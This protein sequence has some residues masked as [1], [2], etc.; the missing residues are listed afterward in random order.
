MLEDLFRNLEA[1]SGTLEDRQIPDER[2]KLLLA[3]AFEVGPVQ[4]EQI[5]GPPSP[6]RQ[7]DWRLSLE[8]NVLL[9]FIHTGIEEQRAFVRNPC[10]IAMMT[11]TS[12]WFLKRKGVPLTAHVAGPAREV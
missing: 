3:R 6:S 2:C 1:Q 12:R 7:C 8:P 9:R 5:D 10:G 11:D 4:P